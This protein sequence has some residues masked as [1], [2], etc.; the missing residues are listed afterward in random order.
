MNKITDRTEFY[1]D[2]NGYQYRRKAIHI[3]QVYKTFP[4]L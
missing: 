3:A 2:F 4:L 1:S